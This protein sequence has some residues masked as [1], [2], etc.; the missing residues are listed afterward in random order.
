M[1]AK[2]LADL[3]VLMQGCKDNDNMKYPREDDQ[4]LVA[5]LRSRKYKIKD[6]LML[7]NNFAKVSD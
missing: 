7:V 4:F 3:K 1:K 5:F 2:G 6:A